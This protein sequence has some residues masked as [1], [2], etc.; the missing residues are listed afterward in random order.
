MFS[1]PASALNLLILSWAWSTAFVS[2][3]SSLGVRSVIDFS[4]MSMPRSSS[5]IST[6]SS[7]TVILV[8][9][10]MRLGSSLMSMRTPIGSPHSCL[11]G[12]YIIGM[13]VDRVRI[14]AS[15]M[16]SLR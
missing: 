6:L 3:A 8:A 5:I 10:P 12:A 1:S 13:R 4:G 15:A 14:V 11:D 2:F 7:A 9:A 16:V